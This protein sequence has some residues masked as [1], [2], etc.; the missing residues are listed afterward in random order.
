MARRTLCVHKVYRQH[1][2]K[3]IA[4]SNNFTLSVNIFCK[5]H[6]RAHK[7]YIKKYQNIIRKI[8]LKWEDRHDKTED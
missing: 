1:F 8:L 6:V 5:K 2:K 3:I 4:H 7:L